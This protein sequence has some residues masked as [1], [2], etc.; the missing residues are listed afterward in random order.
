MVM[1]ALLITAF[2]YRSMTFDGTENIHTCNINNICRV[3]VGDTGQVINITYSI[4]QSQLEITAPD[5]LSISVNGAALPI[6]PLLLRVM[7]LNKFPIQLSVTEQGT[8]LMQIKVI[9]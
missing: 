6:Q 5:S 8:E 2:C 4:K 3:N 9:E 1:M 7:S